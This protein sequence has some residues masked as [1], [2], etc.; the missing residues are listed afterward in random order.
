MELEVKKLRDQLDE[1]ANQVFGLENR[2]EQLALSMEQRKKEI[3]VHLD[4]QEAEKKVLEEERHKISV[5]LAERSIKLDTLKAKY[6][7]LSA[8][9]PYGDE[10]PQSQAYYVIKAAQ[11]REELQRKGDELD[12]NIRV[13]EKEIRALQAT[14]K[15]LNKQN[16]EYREGF[17]VVD[18]NSS[19]AMG[20]KNLRDKLV[21]ASDVLFKR[22]KELQRIHNDLNEDKSKLSSLENENEENVNDYKNKEEINSSLDVELHDKEGKMNELNR[23][24]R[25]QSVFYRRTCGNSADEE[26]IAEKCIRSVEMK[27]ANDNILYCLNE[28][29]KEYPEMNNGLRD[30]LEESNLEIPLRPPSRMNVS[31]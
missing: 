8:M 22:Q 23:K 18:R 9:A 5:E 20:V 25:S 7:T 12:H 4:T 26:T 16:S 21:T 19:D 15:H 24:V 13:A 30:E 29:V 27:D 3:Q 1:R 28:L 17:A 11:K 2:K 31:H 14:L 6:D 10:G